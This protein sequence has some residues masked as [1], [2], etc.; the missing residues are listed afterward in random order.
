MRF[1]KIS[2]GL[3]GCSVVNALLDDKERM[4][5][6]FKRKIFSETAEYF[7]SIINSLLF[8]KTGEQDLFS[9]KGMGNFSDYYKIFSRT[10]GG[11]R[12][13]E[14]DYF[15]R[16]ENLVNTAKLLSE[17]KTVAEENK[18]ILLEYFREL[19]VIKKISNYSRS[20]DDGIVHLGFAY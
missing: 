5:K 3:F 19:I 2:E 15:F 17:E 7:D 14:S 1:R 18:I 12:P 4:D 16:L 13:L 10:I 8:F 6:E 11:S 20:L 9:G